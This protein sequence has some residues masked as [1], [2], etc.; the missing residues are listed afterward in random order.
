M[1][2]K[3]SAANTGKA[4]HPCE[5]PSI[6]GIMCHVPLSVF[7]SNESFTSTVIDKISICFESGE[8]FRDN[9]SKTLTST[10]WHATRINGYLLGT[11][12]TTY[13]M[14]KKQDPRTVKLERRRHKMIQ[15]YNTWMCL[16][17]LQMKR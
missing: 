11:Y 12:G 5:K 2:C 7:E 16:V 10:P 4:G 3:T 9:F 1:S 14:S 6:T 13:R 8:F 15:T 17:E